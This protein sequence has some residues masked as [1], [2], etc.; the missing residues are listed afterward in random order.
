MRTAPLT[1]EYDLYE[2]GCLMIGGIDES[3][4]GPLAGPV[5]ACVVILPQ[6]LVIEGVNDSK[7]LSPKNRGLLASVIKE[8]AVDYAVGWADVDLID[9][10][11]IL[12]ATFI[13]MARAIKGLSRLPDMILIDG[14]RASYETLLP[15][16]PRMFIKRGDAASHSIAAAS[17]IAKTERDKY[18]LKLHEKYKDYGFDT[19]K[20][21]GTFKHMQAL[22]KYGATP[23]HRQ[24][25]IKKII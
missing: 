19:N 21:Y 16:V 5:A 17:I 10:V 13:A 14:L 24:S 6:G 11:N 15:D 23:Y 25:F 3:G 8:K 1:Y 22:R 12:K 20:G 9:E 4:R 7:M 2:Q 18:M